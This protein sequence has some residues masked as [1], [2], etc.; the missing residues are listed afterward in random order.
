M[1]KIAICLMATGLLLTF[2]P[3]QAKAE[4]TVPK[5]AIVATKSE[6]SNSDDKALIL[7]LEEIKEM[8]HSQ[9]NMREKRALRK[10]VRAIQNQMNQ[11]GGLYISVGALIIIILLVIL[12][13]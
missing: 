8:D 7:R 13:F 4:P 6:N 11:S 3:L 9:L 2:Q 1:K 12:I 5:T 10:E